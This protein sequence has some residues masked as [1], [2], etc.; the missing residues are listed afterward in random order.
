MDV[1]YELD[2]QCVGSKLTRTLV[3]LSLC[4]WVICTIIC[5]CKTFESNFTHYTYF[6]EREVNIPGK[7]WLLVVT[8]CM[9]A[10]HRHR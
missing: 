8:V 10:I 7:K 1:E 9:G 4:L 2:T 5:I 6:M 3:S